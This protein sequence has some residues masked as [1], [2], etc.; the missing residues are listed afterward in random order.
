MPA[1]NI[2]PIMTRPI[3]AAYFAAK[4]ALEIVSLTVG[5]IIAAY[6]AIWLTS[7]VRGL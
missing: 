1:T 5:G 2:S 7:A 4:T 3:Y 6:A